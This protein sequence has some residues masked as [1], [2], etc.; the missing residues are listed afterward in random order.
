[1]N[2]T[3]LSLNEIHGNLRIDLVK[4]GNEYNVNLYNTETKELTRRETK[5]LKDASRLFHGL[6][7]LL[8]NSYGNEQYKR[9]YL[10]N[11]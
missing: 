1:M 6:T 5:T 9:N 7:E 11:N 8:I 3:L 10:L 2:Y 4:N